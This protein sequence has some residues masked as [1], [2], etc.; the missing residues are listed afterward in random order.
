[1]GNDIGETREMKTFIK[2]FEI[3]GNWTISSKTALSVGHFMINVR[4]LIWK[5]KD[6]RLG[7]SGKE[8]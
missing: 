8:G 3:A 7:V 1:M 2:L 6:F 4:K 5:D